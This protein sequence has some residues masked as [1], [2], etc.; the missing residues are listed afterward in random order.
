MKLRGLLKIQGIVILNQLRV[1][2]TGLV[3][4]TRHIIKKPA[5]LT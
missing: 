3:V 4:W 1:L 2:N 5:M